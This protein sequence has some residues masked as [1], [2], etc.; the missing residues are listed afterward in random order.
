VILLGVIRKRHPKRKAQP[1]TQKEIYPLTQHRRIDH[2]QKQYEP[3]E[4]LEQGS[5][6]EAGNRVLC[7]NPESCTRIL[8]NL[9][10]DIL[11]PNQD[12][13][14]RPLSGHHFSEGADLVPADRR[15]IGKPS[16]EAISTVL[17]QVR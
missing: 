4:W 12:R 13:P 6:I 17:Y 15:T 1:L 10:Q 9:V 3:V 8:A 16:A 11:K 2:G 5:A 14:D 7:A